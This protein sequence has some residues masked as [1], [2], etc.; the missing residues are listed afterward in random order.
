MRESRPTDVWSSARGRSDSAVTAMLFSSLARMRSSSV[1]S[2]ARCAVVSPSFILCR[3]VALMG[4]DRPGRI[5][6]DRLLTDPPRHV[7]LRRRVVSGIVRP[8]RCSCSART[9]SLSEQVRARARPIDRLVDVVVHGGL[10]VVRADEAG[11]PAR[12][13]VFREIVGQLALQDCGSSSIDIVCHAHELDGDR[14]AVHFEQ[15]APPPARAGSRGCRSSAP[16]AYHYL[17][18]RAADRPP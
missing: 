3:N 12:P 8:D 15:P 5:L 11:N 16:N 2:V 9:P 10:P 13:Q 6:K 14:P 17:E 4:C 7:T 18:S 1:R